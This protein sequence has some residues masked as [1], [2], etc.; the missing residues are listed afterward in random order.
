MQG[1]GRV[2]APGVRA[3]QVNGLTWGGA[4]GPP[5]GREGPAGLVLVESA[6]SP[7]PHSLA[8][9][10]ALWCRWL[11][12]CDTWILGCWYKSECRSKENSEKTRE[13]FQTPDPSEVRPGAVQRP[14]SCPARPSA[15][16]L[17]QPAPHLRVRGAPALAGGRQHGRGAAARAAGPAVSDRGPG[18]AA[19]VSL[20]PPPGPAPPLP[21]PLPPPSTGPSPCC[22]QPLRRCWVPQPFLVTPRLLT[23]SGR[24]DVTGASVSLPGQWVPVTGGQVQ[25]GGPVLRATPEPASGVCP[26][27]LSPAAS[28][29]P[30]WD[31]SLRT[32]G[33]PDASQDPQLQGLLQHLLRA[34]ASGAPE[35]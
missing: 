32:A 18:P 26:L 3:S 16:G 19:P 33:C 28:E 34:E 6:R 25:P 12:V 30:L 35:R 7:A 22:P 13:Y 10:P 11:L 1:G 27:R 23:G 5:S 15:P 4:C 24:C 31:A 17:E 29:R 21:P 8:R 9:G 20:L 14:L 2:W